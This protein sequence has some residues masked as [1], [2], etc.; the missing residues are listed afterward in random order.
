MCAGVFVSKQLLCLRENLMRHLLAGSRSYLRRPGDKK[1]HEKKKQG[2]SG[3]WA[4]HKKTQTFIYSRLLRIQQFIHKI[5]IRMERKAAYR[6]CV[7]ATH[8][9]P[10]FGFTGR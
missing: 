10:R 1:K 5:P 9:D 4:I 8:N 2:L 6:M 7:Q 3:L